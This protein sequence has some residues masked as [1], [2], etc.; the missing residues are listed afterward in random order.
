VGYS[1]TLFFQT[2]WLKTLATEISKSSFLRFRTF[3]ANL[4]KNNQKY[5]R[6]RT[7]KTLATEILKMALYKISVANV[8]KW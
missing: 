2:P 3:V 8:F 4:F 1:P 5:Q 7:L 6:F